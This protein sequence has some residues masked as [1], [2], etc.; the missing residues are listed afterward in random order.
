MGDDLLCF[1][2]WR[3][4]SV[5]TF[6]PRHNDNVC[7]CDCYIAASLWALPLLHQIDMISPGVVA[8]ICV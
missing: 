5:S 8:R 1:A 7:V 6:H 2:K 4:D 3:D